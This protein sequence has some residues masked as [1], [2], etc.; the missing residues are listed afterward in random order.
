MSPS[1]AVRCHLFKPVIEALVSSDKSA[2][3]AMVD[4]AEFDSQLQELARI[5]ELRI[6]PPH[7]VLGKS[8][9]ECPLIS[10]THGRY[11]SV[12]GQTYL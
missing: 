11:A 3:A 1:R 5:C 4:F 6:K 7:L 2:G 8:N 10:V 12:N 9:I